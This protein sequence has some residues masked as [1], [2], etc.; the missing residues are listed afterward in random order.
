MS[1][2]EQVVRLKRRNHE[3]LAEKLARAFDLDELDDQEVE[4][5]AEYVA[6]LIP[7]DDY[8]DDNAA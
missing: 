5:V 3:D 2:P 4:Q 7:L 6:D 1:K 8:R